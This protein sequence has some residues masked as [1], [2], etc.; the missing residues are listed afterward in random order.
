MGPDRKSR[1]TR[2]C[3]TG[4]VAAERQDIEAPTPWRSIGE[5]TAEI[6]NRLAAGAAREAAE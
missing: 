4:A 6:V 2:Q 1:P 3:G 5:L